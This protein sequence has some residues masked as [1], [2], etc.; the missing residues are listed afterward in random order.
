M[1][2]VCHAPQTS[3]H[4]SGTKDGIITVLKVA[5]IIRAHMLHRSVDLICNN[6]Y[7]NYSMHSAS[8]VLK[9]PRMIPGEHTPS[10]PDQIR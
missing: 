3:W 4:N 6:A 5:I 2:G 1:S 7:E 10:M 8:R 9:R